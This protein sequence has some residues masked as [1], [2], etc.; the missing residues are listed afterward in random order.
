MVS[1]SIDSV[2]LGRTATAARAAIIIL[3]L[4]GTYFVA[5]KLGL[6]LAFL[7]A[8]A[9]AVWPPTGIAIAALLLLGPRAWPGVFL[10][11]FAANITTAGTAATSLGI[12]LGNTLEGLVAAS[13]V[14][15]FA[16]GVR[17]FERAPDLFRYALLAA[18]LSTTI[19]ATIGVTSLAL[20]GLVQGSEYGAV[21]FTWWLGDAAGALIVAPLLVLWAR[22]SASGR[23]DRARQ[24][25]AALVILI[26]VAVGNIVFAT[27]L[28]M[29]FAT[30]PILAWTAFRLGPRETAAVTVLL[31]AVAIWR[32]LQ[33]TGSFAV[34]S[35][36]T[37][38]LLLQAFM[39]TM[40]LVNLPLATV[41]AERREVTR[42]LRES[43]GRFRELYYHERS[44]AEIL[45]RSLLPRALPDIPGVEAAARYLPAEPEAVGGDW[46]DALVLPGGE[47]ALAIGDVSGHGAEAAAV[48]GKLRNTLWAYA[49]E[50]LD[51]ARIL[52]R[53]NEA[54]E[55]GEMATLLY[56]VVDLLSWK[57]RYVSAGHPPALLMGPEGAA[58]Y[59][60]GSDLPLGTK[61]DRRYREQA[62][63][64]TAGSML[65]LYT[66][67]LIEHRESS[68][69]AGLGRLEASFR[70]A[71]G[72]AVEEAM[73][74]VVRK[75]LE[76]RAPRDDVA[77]LLVRIAALE[78]KRLTLQLPAVPASLGE[79]R[80]ALRRWLAPKP[81]AEGDLSALLIATGEAATNTV[82]HAYGLADATFT[83][84]ATDEDG[85]LTIAVSDTGAWRPPRNVQHR[86]RGFRVMH[87]LVDAV[88]VQTTEHGTS[89]RLMRHIRAGVRT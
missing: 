85:L 23:W 59:L 19:S 28:P 27:D 64:L 18:V 1:S 87:G 22:P 83:V 48:M 3:A 10:G 75:T 80:H 76:G 58:T 45:Q 53:L 38:L 39:A 61:L 66:D 88:D 89:V 30:V 5:A 54:M 79:I 7:N 69:D 51:P 33:G 78:G 62:A 73:D 31:A 44:T 65:I 37:S 47:L 86:G 52:Q 26:T 60:H 35:E 49:L 14:M 32:T 13:L 68:L 57:V 4:A 6:R 12:A 9:T 36:N 25:E 55:P 82:E 11:A 84:E 40:A 67:G 74:D 15:R 50:G 71:S 81:L 8:S 56:M 34:G 63:D 43:E 2:P 77:V 42:L 16:G 70:E 24:I 29:A 41:V 17:T 20:A 72:A 21:W 46:Y